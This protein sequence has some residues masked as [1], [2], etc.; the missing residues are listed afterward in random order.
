MKT[1]TP[2]GPIRRNMVGV[3]REMTKF[4]VGSRSVSV[5]PPYREREQSDAQSQFE[6]APKTCATGWI[7]PEKDSAT[8]TCA[9]Q[10]R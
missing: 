3:A 6:P 10:T 8:T 7:E 5:D 1:P 2:D 9:C 4:P